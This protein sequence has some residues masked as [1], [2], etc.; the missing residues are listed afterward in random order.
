MNCTHCEASVR[1]DAKFCTQCGKKLGI[2]CGACQALCRLDSKFCTQC[3][4]QLSGA[5]RPQATANA[6]DRRVV[7]VLFT[8]VSGFTA[9][10]EKLDPQ[11][12]TEIVNQFFEVLTEPIYRFGGV[13]D[14]YIGDAI[15]ALFGAPIAHE[16]DPE[17]AVHAAYEM[18][19][20]A[21]AFAAKLEERTGITLRVR[22]GIHTGLVVAGA[23]GGEQKR[24]YTVMGETVNLA[25][26]MEAAARPGK[27]LVSHETYRLASSAFEFQAMPSVTV[28]GRS[29][30]VEAYEVVA[31]R[32]KAESGRERGAFVGRRHEIEQLAQ[33]WHDASEG[34]A[35][36]VVV[37]GEAGMGKS[38]L[39]SQF[40][41]QRCT[42]AP[43]TIR[44]RCQSY[45]STASFGLVTNLIHYWLDAPP[46]TSTAELRRRLGEWCMRIAPDEGDRLAD[47][48]GAFL[49]LE[50]TDAELASLS[51]EQR[52]NA[53][54]AAL[55]GV[56][57]R[58]A[59]AGP[60]LLSLEDLQWAD[61]ASLE[62]FKAFL[63]ALGQ[64]A[65]SAKVMILCQQ[66]TE[67]SRIP[68]DAWKH[69]LLD[70][71]LSPFGDDESLAIAAAILHTSAEAI[72]G[73]APLAPLVRQVLE[74]AAGNPFYLHE[75]ITSLIDG[76]AIAQG[77]DGTWTLM[78][79]EA[80]IR[81]PSTIH[82]AVASR[83]DRLGRSHKGL[84]QVGALLGRTFS[85]GIIEQVGKRVTD[86]LHSLQD[87]CRMGFLY[88][89]SQGDFAFTQPLIQEV[90]YHS[91]LLSSRKELHGRTGRALEALFAGQL[92]E[93]AHLLAHHF[94][95]A[96]QHAPGLK[97]LFLSAKRSFAF[98]DLSRARADLERAVQVMQQVE[99]LETPA[100][101]EVHWLLG[102]VLTSL[103]Q[104]DQAFIS[105]GEA[106]SLAPTP[107]ARA[108]VLRTQGDALERKGEY[109]AALDSFTQGH[110]VL[111]VAAKLERAPLLSKMGYA[112]YRLGQIEECI[113]LCMEALD[114]LEGTG[115][116]RELGQAHS[117]LGICYN[118]RGD[119][120]RA[121]MHTR[122]SLEFRE[123]CK[124]ITG[125]ATCYNSLANIHSNLGEWQEADDFYR[126]ALLAYERIG[127][128]YYISLVHN[129]HGTLLLNRGDLDGAEEHL[130]KGL[131]LK[132]KIGE[133][134]GEGI[135]LFNLG[136]I[137]SRRG[138]GQ[139][140][141]NA[142]QAALA[143][144]QE[145]GS[146]EVYPEVFMTIGRAWADL[147][148]AA[149]AWSFVNEARKFA[150]ELGDDATLAVLPRIESQIHLVEGDL[151]QARLKAEEA[152]A[153]M[154]PLDSPLDLARAHA[155]LSRVLAAG[156]DVA[157]SQKSAEEARAMFVQLG[158]AFELSQLAQM[159]PAS[160]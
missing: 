37:N 26:N 140:A 126:R 1:P 102:Q 73:E 60:L 47:R 63:Q 145:L 44:A 40:V 24:D 141:V 59:D 21:K 27:A 142:M 153:R 130:R 15:M 118:R 103:S 88:Q 122:L 48:L 79:A 6:G 85:L 108:N 139:S 121:I 18:Q 65:G 80:D 148:V 146:K 4:V 160:S 33:A 51:Q 23:V 95:L 68:L 119:S 36:L 82:G 136:D 12:V 74:R 147:G 99:E 81:L 154:A 158:A 35:Q 14:K 13:V 78:M 67:A 134:M 5:A 125:Q 157:G 155:Q 105:L 62:W 77:A 150:V 111:P 96:D 156:G 43:T 143:I 93:N 129:N 57:L 144:F 149:E 10:S 66:R 9:M 116:D 92:E 49:G 2:P 31:P 46:T 89:N 34:K 101:W 45:T 114:L 151:D 76:K 20:A 86:N 152:I 28:K 8:D 107:S 17:R 137:A 7:T 16:D 56:L 61:E 22:I 138:D 41:Q 133:R 120:V 90:A 128:L 3:G 84:L 94:L 113:Q 124:D 29:A 131:A 91:L 104:Y 123:A 54:L 58:L 11:Q 97:Y 110:D 135:V 83:L 159:A 32:H 30:P 69:G 75:L 25:Q 50:P 115:L 72:G 70:I 53:A 109:Q 87:L 100:K 132:Q 112:K 98:F 106:L 64:Q 19:E 71:Q 42:P 52:R 39:V 127:D 55:N 38:R 117:Y